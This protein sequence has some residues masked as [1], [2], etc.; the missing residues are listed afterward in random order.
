MAA[1]LAGCSQAAPTPTPEPVAADFT[2]TISVSGKVLPA[3]WANLSFQAAGHVVEVN[4]RLGDKVSAGQVLARLEDSDAR[5]A[6]A[7]AEAMLKRA[8]AALAQLRAGARPAEIASAE[9]GV[10]AARA[11]LQRLEDGPTPE[12]IEV[13]RAAVRVAEAEL[14]RARAGA[15]HSQVVAAQTALGKAERALQQAQAAY[16]LLNSYSPAGISAS[17]QA[18]EL[19]QATLD[20]QAAKAQYDDVVAGPD[21]EDA[22]V[23]LARLAQARAAFAQVTAAPRP[24]DLAAA[25]AEIARAQAQ[26]DALLAGARPEQLAAAEAEVASAEAAL[27][28]ARAA[29][30]KRQLVAPFDGSVGSVFVHVGELATPGQAVLTLGDLAT[31]RVETTDLSEIDAVRVTPDRAVTVTFDALPGTTVPGKVTRIAPMSTPGQSGVNYVAV[32]ELEQMDSRVAWGM[33]AFVD[34]VANDDE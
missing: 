17:P 29:L 2:P 30:A 13:S 10:A 12:E 23:A 3:R 6:V 5:A 31:L 18:L 21:E 25:Q 22:N 1:L 32:V 19:E 26:R 11:A 4:A 9:A 28:Q 15:D 24:A 33:T 34:I 20:Y 7:Q 14:A 16:D 8:Q 27:A